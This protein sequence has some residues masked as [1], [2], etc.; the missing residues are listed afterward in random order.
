MI[1]TNQFALG[2]LALL[3]SGAGQIKADSLTLKITKKYLNLPVSHQIDRNVL[4]MKV[5]GKTERKFDI[6]LAADK[7][8][9]W[10]FCDMSEYKN[11]DVTIVYPG[12]DGTLN[13]LY[14]DNEIAG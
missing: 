9:Y 3:L 2:V 1:K 5:D 13:Q 12:P 14:Q 11:K 4:S 8:D 7:P 10:V 6:R